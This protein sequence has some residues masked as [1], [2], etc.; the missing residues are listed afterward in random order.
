MTVL[1]GCAII[2]MIKLIHG[3]KEMAKF[4]AEAIGKSSRIDRLKDDL[5][6][7]MP[8]IESARARQLKASDRQ[9]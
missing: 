6:R 3:G 4:F 9:T 5:F 8:E 1:L 2:V 7:K